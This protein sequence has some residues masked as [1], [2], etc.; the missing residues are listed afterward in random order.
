MELFLIHDADCGLVRC[1]TANQNTTGKQKQ[2]VLF[3]P[4]VATFFDILSKHARHVFGGFSLGFNFWLKCIKQP[5]TH[6]TSSVE[7]LHQYA[8]FRG[9]SQT[10]LGL[11]RRSFSWNAA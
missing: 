8:I 2:S 1:N 4:L 6:E 11:F 7:R 10:S 3:L 5:K 9:K